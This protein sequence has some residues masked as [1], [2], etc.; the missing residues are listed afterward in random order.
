MFDTGV[1]ARPRPDAVARRRRHHRDRARARRAGDRATSGEAVELGDPVGHT[2]RPGHGGRLRRRRR[3]RRARSTSRRCWRRPGSRPEPWSSGRDDE[4][5]ALFAQEAEQRL[6]DLTA[7]PA[8]PRGGRQRRRARRLDLPRGPHAQGRRPPSSGLDAFSH[9]AHAMED[10]LEQLRSGERMATPGAHRRRARRASTACRRC[11]RAA[12]AGADCSAAGRRARCRRCTRWPSTAAT[13]R[14]RTPAAEPTTDERRRGRRRGA[15][16]A[17]RRRAT[18]PRSTPRRCACRWPGSTSSIRLVGESAAAH[19]RVGRMLSERLGD[20]PVDASTSSA[21]SPACSTTCRSGRCGPAWCRSSTIT[22]MLQRAVRDVARATGKDVRWEVRG[23]DTELDRG[24]LQQLADPLLHLVRN[25]VDH[26]IE[27]P[28][29]ARGRRQA[30]AGDRPLPRHAARLRG[31]HHRHRRRAGHRRRPGPGRGGPR[32]RRHVVA[33]RR[34]GRSTSSSAAA[35]RPPTFVSEISGRGVGLDVVRANVEAA[36]G[37]VE[38]R[39]EPG[40]GTEFRIIVPI[41]LAVLPVPARRG[42]RPAP[43]PPDALDRARPDRGASRPAPRAGRWCGSGTQAV[44]LAE[45]GARPSACPPTTTGPIVVVAGLTRQH[46][47]RVGAPASASAT[48]WSRA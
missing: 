5:L 26:G 8:R 23:E 27:T 32:R 15:A 14:R 3:A 44:P 28:E 19:L 42:R 1:P 37:R 36:R 7:P 13:R 40:A 20:R 31:D 25:A 30:G 47:F 22:D 17:P 4:F 18:T 16:G 24:V 10:L 34:G 29:R 43:R 9:V 11:C 45:P 39:T 38:I 48:S 35:C 41:T 21:S 33:H 12:I 2:R 46:A 6:A